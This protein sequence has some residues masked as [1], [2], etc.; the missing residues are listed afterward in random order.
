MPAY[1]YRSPTETT[2]PVAD[3]TAGLWTFATPVQRLLLTNRSGDLAYARFNS[4]AGVGISADSHD[5]MLPAE[6]SILIDAYKWGLTQ[7]ATVGVWFEAG[8]D[9]DLFTIRGV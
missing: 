3:T 9:V 6:E 5:I 4:T 7:I 1:T 2:T 8:S